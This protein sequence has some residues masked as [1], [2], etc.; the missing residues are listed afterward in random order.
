[1]LNELVTPAGRP[2]VVYRATIG[3]DFL[4]KELVVDGTLVTLQVCL[5]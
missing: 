4:T 1:M 3:H 2:R 5:C